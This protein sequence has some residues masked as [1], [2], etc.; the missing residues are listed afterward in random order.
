MPRRYIDYPEA[1]AFWNEISTLGAFLSFGSFIFFIGVVFYTLLAGKR[2]EEPAYWGEHADTL[3][4][5]HSNPPPH[6]TYETLPTPDMWRKG[7]YH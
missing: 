5:I 3:E 7:A 2:I 4:W 6:H 1:F